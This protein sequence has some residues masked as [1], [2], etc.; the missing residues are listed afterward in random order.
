M[1]IP[2]RKSLSLIIFLLLASG[3]YAE[4]PEQVKALDREWAQ[5]TVRADV[6]TLSRLLS[7]DLIYTHTD[8]ETQTKRE[9]IASV[10]KG[11]IR[12]NSIEFEGSTARVYGNTGVTVSRLRIK[13][14]VGNRHVNLH[15]IFLHVWVNQNGRWQMVAHQ[16]TKIN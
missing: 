3:T 10:S 1:A 13:L 6:A 11:E 14:T 2:A 4:T 9:F 7:D 15:P 12:Y 16:A 8:A 5:A